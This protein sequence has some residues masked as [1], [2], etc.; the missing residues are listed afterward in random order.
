M[1]H[2]IGLE[3]GRKMIAFFKKGKSLVLNAKFA[4]HDILASSESFD[5]RAFDTLLSQP[6]CTAIRIYYGMDDTFKV[7]AI[8]VGV[9]SM[10]EDILPSAASGR[11]EN[12]IV[13]TGDRCPVNCPPPSALTVNSPQD[14]LFHT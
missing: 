5:R 13:E 9:N 11:I 2:F 6:D 14:V 12:D 4:K 8:I 7:H 10:G 1:S 3:T